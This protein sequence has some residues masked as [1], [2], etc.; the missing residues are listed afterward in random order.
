M[1]M[2]TNVIIVWCSVNGDH[3]L[4]IALLNYET[5]AGT[6]IIILFCN[7]YPDCSSVNLIPQDNSY[8]YS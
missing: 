6:I 7:K 5:K 2:A 8:N 1:N 4:Y 3:F